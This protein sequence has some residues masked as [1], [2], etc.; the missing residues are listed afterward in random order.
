MRELQAEYP[1]QSRWSFLKRVLFY[2]VLYWLGG[3][4][5][6]SLFFRTCRFL[7]KN[8][9]KVLNGSVRNFPQ[10]EFFMNLREQ[11]SLPL[12]RLMTRRI[13]TYCN[14]DLD[15]RA[16]RG[17]LLASLLPMK[18]C[19]RS[20]AAP[21]SFWI[22]L[23]L[24]PDQSAAVA[25]LWTAGFDST[26]G[27]SLRPVDPPADRPEL[28]PQVARRLLASAISLPL[29]SA[30]PEAEIRRMASVLAPVIAPHDQKV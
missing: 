7:G 18:S 4:I 10:T 20:D 28:E 21:H 2:W 3:R 25:T 6:F 1:V 19:P 14:N 30:I 15:R 27:S 8:F 13:T 26:A 11:P 9:D 24:V 12:L 29:Y 17:R 23:L 5:A 22:F 16:A